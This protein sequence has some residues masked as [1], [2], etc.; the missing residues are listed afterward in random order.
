MS[1]L[2]SVK[3]KF[4]L[5][6]ISWI[7][8]RS[9]KTFHFYQNWL[10][11][12]HF[13][14]MSY[15]ER[16]APLKNSPQALLPG[17]QSVFMVTKSYVPIRR[18]HGVL[19]NLRVASY[20]QNE[21]YHHWF[22]QDLQKASELIRETHPQ[23]QVLVGTDS[24]AFLERDHA[25]Q[26]GLG[27]VGKNTCLIDRKLGSFFFLGEILCTLPAPTDPPIP[28]HDFCGHCTKCIDICPT[29]AI[30]APRQLNATKCISYWTIE[31]KGIAPLEI[32]EKMND[33]FFGCDLCQSICPW[34][35]KPFAGDPALNTQGFLNSEKGLEEDLKLVLTKSDSDLKALIRGTPFERS[36]A[37]GLRRNA[38]YVIGNRRLKGL[39]TEVASLLTNPQLGELAAWALEKTKHPVS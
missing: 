20:A 12:G 6:Q 2:E 18:S 19:K 21:D 8:L 16:H 17:A 30:E 37:F 33:W 24:L 31:S 23:A 35:Q 27:W 36:K 10:E 29:K 39:E 5:D 4:Q 25:A 1:L 15:L 7:P 13:G 11:K 22:Y 26:A 14:E 32:R 34:N 38:L 28:I 3:E 9:P